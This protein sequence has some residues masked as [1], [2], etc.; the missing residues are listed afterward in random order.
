MVK[1]KTIIIA[2]GSSPFNPNDIDFKHPRIYDSNTI[3]DMK[4]HPKS[5]II[6]GAGVIGSEYASIFKGLGLRVTLINTRERLLSFLDDEV[7]HALS[8]HFINNG[9]SVKHNESYSHINGCSNHVEVKLKS[10]KVLTADC[11]LFANGRSGNTNN[12]GLDKIGLE[13]D[14][15]GL[16]SVNDKYQTDVP[17]IYA[18]GDV[19]GYPSLASTSFEQGRVVGEHVACESERKLSKTLPS[20]IYT[21]PD[22]SFVGFTEQELTKGGV[23]YEI[24]KAHFKHLAGAQIADCEVG[25]LKIL[26]CPDSFKVLGIHCFGE[27]SAEII[28]IGQ[29]VMESSDN[30]IEYFANATFN[31]PTMAEAYRV[32]ALNGIN[33]LR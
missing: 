16:L 25:F 4:E 18:I 19:I 7:T 20:G 24:G 21:I 12:L 30:T 15:R 14:S 9:I 6:Y 10:N 3:L 17:N 23:P 5:I 29:A 31:Y 2:T 32:A 1:A 28:H 22:I 27:R 13:T 8:Y 33:K 26:F 11:L